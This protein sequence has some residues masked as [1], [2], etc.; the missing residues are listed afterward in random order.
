MDE[1]NYIQIINEESILTSNSIE[2]I[3]K[4]AYE[5]ISDA[6]NTSKE[7]YIIKAMLINSSND[8]STQ[9]KLISMDKNYKRR[10][11]ERWQNVLYFAIISFGVWGIAIAAPF[12]LKMFVNFSLHNSN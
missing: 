6:E 5:A 3:Y 4:K 12:L 2:N 10:N 1:N 11:H 9:E 8:M 7:K